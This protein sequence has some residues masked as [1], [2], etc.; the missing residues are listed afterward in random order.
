MRKFPGGMH[1]GQY[2][3]FQGKI[4]HLNLL[5]GFADIIDEFLDSVLVLD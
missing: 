2:C 1:D 5:Q 4:A 3:F